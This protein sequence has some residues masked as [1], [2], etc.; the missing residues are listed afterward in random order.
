MRRLL[1]GLL[2]WAV[3][4]SLAACLDDTPVA[5]GAPSVH[6]LLS[7]NIVGA[8]AGGTVRI[9][10]GY[11]SSR[12][13]FV[14]LRS[15]PEA[16]TVGAGTTVVVPVTVDIGPCL[17]DETRL[18]AAQSGCLL[19]IELTLADAAGAVIDTQ[20]RDSQSG[21]VSPGQS[22]DFGTVTVGVTV[23]TITV[24]PQ[25]LG[26]NVSDQQQLTATVRDAT[27]T[28]TTALPVTWTTSDASVAQLTA[29]SGGAVTVRALKLGT[30]AVTASAGGKT[31]APVSV[32]VVPPAPLIIRQRQGDGCVIV[33]QTINLDV[34]TSPGPVAWT[35]GNSSVATVS[36]TGV[37]TGVANGQASMTATSGNRT[38]VVTV[39]VTG[40]LRV[41][42]T[43]LSLVAAQTAQISATGVSGGSLSFASSAPTIASVDPS[44]LVRGVGVGQATI[45]VTFTAPSGNQSLPVQ[46]TVTAASL[47]ITPTQ[48]TAAI[49]RTAR[50]T[51]AVKDANGATLPGVTAAWTI[52]D[53]TI[54]SLSSASG[55]SV[56][57]K[58]LKVGSTVVRATAGGVSGTAQFVATAPLPAARLEKVAGDGTACAT[59]SSA[60]TFIVRAVDVNGAPVAGASVLWSGTAGCPTGPVTTSDADGLAT[61]TNVCSAV[62]PGAYTQTATLAN[63]QQQAL[64]NYTL[65]GLTLTSKADSNGLV[66]VTIQSSF[67]T[68]Q[69]LVASIKYV[70]GP[71]SNYITAP[72]LD[73]TSTP[74]TLTLPINYSQLPYGTYTFDVTVTTTTPGLGQGVRTLTFIN[75]YYVGYS[76]GTFGQPSAAQPA[77]TST[78]VA[79]TAPAGKRP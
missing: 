72:S 12:Q 8:L 31:S 62:Q 77:A 76:V 29:G 74:A 53:A 52:D 57:V 6:A 60:C 65:R 22:V 50:F 15:S 5:A 39:C 26:M 33:G 47:S 3:P 49:G 64:F 54:G 68:A 71:A 28:V 27:G 37:V 61:A 51:A 20:T 13:A 63:N 7:A 58:A 41:G 36:Q 59:W 69:G 17:A 11:R 32:S 10:V 79:G 42:A 75:D 24:T 23:S 18:A 16:I 73:R 4:L 21:A 1:L 45:T 43:S 40:P 48:G 38:G 78:T 70:S 14:A 30:A 66:T 55:A 67:G 19:T 2:G 56:D 9:R 46:V 25:S 34:D 44:G 35:S